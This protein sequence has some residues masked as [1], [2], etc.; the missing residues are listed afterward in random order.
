MSSMAESTQNNMDFQPTS[1]SNSPSEQSLED[2]EVGSATGDFPCKDCDKRYKLPYQLRK[3]ER[4]HS[5]PCKCS[6][7]SYSTAQRKDL[8]RHYWTTHENYAREHNIPDDK[9]GCPYCRE[10]GRSD[11]IRRHIRRKHPDR[12]SG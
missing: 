10:R 4:I 2:S 3:H 5:K 8:D 9:I 12:S 6:L 1:L 11:N 7:C